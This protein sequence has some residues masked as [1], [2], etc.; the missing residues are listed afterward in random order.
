MSS[1]LEFASESPDRT[2]DAGRALGEL[3][4]GGEV[5]ELR[6]PLG[7]GKTQFAKGL[8]VGL[9]VRR[10]EMIVSPTFVL[11]R[12]YAGRVA[13]YHCDAYRLGS[14]DELLDLGLEE[15]LESGAVVAIEWADKFSG[16]LSAP[17]VRVELEY[18]GRA[19]RRIRFQLPDQIRPAA[20][21]T[22]LDQ[23]SDGGD[24]RELDMSP[25]GGDTADGDA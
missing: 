23:R 24:R 19:S 4:R 7:A 17:I 15:A 9:G 22:L 13:F 1:T 16:A 12:A 18:A 3:L 21:R 6:G 8:A 5:V 25:G 20:F 10:D 14:A 2:I 11:V